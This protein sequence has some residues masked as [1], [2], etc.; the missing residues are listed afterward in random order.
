[1]LQDSDYHDLEDTVQY[2][3]AKKTQCDLIVSNDENF[4]SKSI[5]LISAS[6]FCNEFNL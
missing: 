3:L 4:T 1:M 6:D 2:L 5:R